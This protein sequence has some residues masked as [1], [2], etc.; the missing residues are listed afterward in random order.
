MPI[1]RGTGNRFEFVTTAGARARQLLK[2]ATPRVAGD[3]KKVTLAMREVAQG[4]VR[5][6]EPDKTDDK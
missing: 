3:H 6:I 1:D 5:K 4:E 2:G